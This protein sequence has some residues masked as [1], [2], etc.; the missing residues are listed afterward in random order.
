MLFDSI[1]INSKTSKINLWCQNSKQ[2]LPLRIRKDTDWEGASNVL[3]FFFFALYGAT[4]VHSLLGELIKPYTNDL[5]TFVNM[6]H[7]NFSKVFLKTDLQRWNQDHGYLQD[8]GR[9]NDWSRKGHR[10]NVPGVLAKFSF[11]PQMFI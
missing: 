5:C 3:F 8:G 7:F 11:Q 9:E 2:L 1:Y 10:R 4:C 6:L